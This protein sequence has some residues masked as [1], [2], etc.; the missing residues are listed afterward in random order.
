MV[1]KKAHLGVHDQPFL[2]ET[3]VAH[4]IRGAS[5]SGQVD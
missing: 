3:V 5:G 2:P 4:C 1:V